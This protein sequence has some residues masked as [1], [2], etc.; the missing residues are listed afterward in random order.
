MWLGGG[1]DPQLAGVGKGKRLV[2]WRETLK[3][4]IPRAKRGAQKQDDVTQQHKRNRNHLRNT[5]SPKSQ[6]FK[7][8]LKTRVLCDIGPPR[9]VGSQ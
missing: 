3:I 7:L 6:A 4:S 5:Q 8:A 2:G 9:S 1:S